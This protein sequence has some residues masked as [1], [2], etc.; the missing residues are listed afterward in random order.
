MQQKERY[1]R[2]CDAVRDAIRE[3]LGTEYEV[4]V[5]SV[6]KNNNVR[7]E[8]LLIRKAQT[9]VM[10]AIY[11]NEFYR[12]YKNGKAWETILSDILQSYEENRLTCE[13]RI[14]FRY[15]DLKD[16]IF[17]RL[18]NYERNRESLEVMP[19][20]RVGGCAVIFQCMIFGGDKRMGTIRLTQ[21]HLEIWGVSQ[22]EVFA[23]AR[24]NTTRLLPPSLR[25]MDEVME[26]I[27]W[28]GLGR[29]VKE[30]SAEETEAAVRRILERKKESLPMYVL[31]NQR[32]SFG[33]S[34]LLEVRLLDAFAKAIADDFYI[35][36]S[37]VHEVLLLPLRFA[38]EAE[39]IE[40][41][42]REI[43]ETQ[44]PETEYLSDDV[45]LYSEFRALLPERL[46]EG[47]GA[48]RAADFFEN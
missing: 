2:F 10:P 15:D 30:E 17:Y 47:D 46:L 19:Y 38:P 41:M 29:S 36:P 32:G 16:Y 1:S 44:I 48:G 8:S 40:T 31:S 43:N 42:V 9:L 18:V 5:H 11:L 39:K 27:L 21:E 6:M 37:S 26:E 45:L 25:P 24:V 7:L 23:R 35:L 22:E 20:Y 33:A 13:E 3:R 4:S 34:A 28:E 14:S 12:E